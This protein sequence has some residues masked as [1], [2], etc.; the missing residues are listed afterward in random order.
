MPAELFEHTIRGSYS[1]SY[2]VCDGIDFSGFPVKSVQAYV[3]GLRWDFAQKMFQFPR[4]EQVKMARLPFLERADQSDT[5]PA[6]S[7]AGY[8]DPVRSGAAGT[9]AAGC[10]SR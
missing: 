1:I 2:R 9:S 8:T 5:A 4:P 10:S 7:D 3:V 6:Q